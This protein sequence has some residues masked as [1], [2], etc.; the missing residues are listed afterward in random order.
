M[1][2][3]IPTALDFSTLPR[4]TFAL[5]K[6]TQLRSPAVATAAS[7][8]IYY[9]NARDHAIYLVAGIRD[10]NGIRTPQKQQFYMP[11]AF[12]RPDDAS[13]GATALRAVER[14][15]PESQPVLFGVSPIAPFTISGPH[16]AIIAIREVPVLTPYMLLHYRVRI[17]NPDA[18]ARQ[19]DVT[20][21][22]V[23]DADFGGLESALQNYPQLYPW[24]PVD[25]TLPT[26]PFTSDGLLYRNTPKGFEVLV[27][28][29]SKTSQYGPEKWMTTSGGFANPPWSRTPDDSAFA[30]HGREM[31]EELGKRFRIIRAKKPFA[32][33]GPAKKNLIWNAEQH[34]LVQT[35]KTDQDL[36]VVTAVYFALCAGGR[37]EA[38]E[39][40]IKGEW[41]LAEKIPSDQ[42][43]WFI[44][45]QEHV[46]DAL[47]VEFPTEKSIVYE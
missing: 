40:V 25:N 44:N 4:Q 24:R 43:P 38:T 23:H 31:L 32:V 29:R 9:R 11:G 6:P 14:D 34:K 28:Q 22:R 12:V 8:T 19:N 39:E 18:L 1:A 13:P 33:Y 15:F 7:A 37:F 5:W 2:E 17:E 20:L 30:A 35:E 16:V 41:L 45:H 42:R 3:N 10:L 26:V 21:Q 36:P 27:T 46:V 47:S